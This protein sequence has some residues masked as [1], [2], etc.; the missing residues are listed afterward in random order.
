MAI[1]DPL[2]EHLA[3]LADPIIDIDLGT[4]QAQSGFTAHGDEVFT[5]PTVQTS[6][7][8]IAHLFRVATPE[9]L[10]HEPVVVDTIIPGMPL[11]K[12]IPMII[13]YLLKDIPVW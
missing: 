8:D 1:D 5:L 12:P 11:F 2:M 6:I 9:H 4:T 7:C 13:E 10:V 3:D